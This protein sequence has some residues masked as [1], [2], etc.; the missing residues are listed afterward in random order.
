[1]KYKNV[2][3]SDFD[4]RGKAF[5]FRQGGFTIVELIL[6]ASLVFVVGFCVYKAFSA[7]I[8]IWKWQIANKSR[9][10]IN[11]FFE[12]VAHDLRNN[13]T[14]TEG[15]MEGDFWNLSFNTHNAAYLLLPE[16][17]LIA[18]EKTVID[19][20]D[21][22]EYS[23]DPEEK[24]VKRT[25]LNY[26]AKEPYSDVTVLSEVE[27]VLFGYYMLDLKGTGIIQKDKNKGIVPE[28]VSV[29]VTMLDRYGDEKTYKKII[30]IPKIG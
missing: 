10:E 11:M 1:M 23:Y 29:E 15:D 16:E 19:V 28:A 24:R 14:I 13:T 4:S 25:A 21:K 26:Q 17:G 18:G 30:E 3:H 6:A 8:D 20:M 2:R 22:V 27:E 9:S 7:G 5:G 12:K